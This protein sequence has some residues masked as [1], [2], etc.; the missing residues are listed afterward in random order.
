MG[1]LSIAGG[2][3]LKLKFEDDH[4]D[5]IDTIVING[6]E[7]RSEGHWFITD[8]DVL[9]RQDLNLFRVT[10][11]GRNQATVEFRCGS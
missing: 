8:I 1:K 6:V 11:L 9:G 2:I 7:V 4:G 5:P 10:D 3:P